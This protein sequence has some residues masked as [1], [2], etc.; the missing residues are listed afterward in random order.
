MLEI[1]ARILKP[2]SYVLEVETG[3]WYAVKCEGVL[4]TCEVVAYGD[5]Y[6]FQV[7]AMQPA[8]YKWPTPKDETFCLWEKLMAKLNALEVA[9]NR[10][11]SK[12]AVKF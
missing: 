8:R 10:G 7:S 12:F 1:T 2:D 11:R 3:D 5:Q 9:N 6:D 4:Y